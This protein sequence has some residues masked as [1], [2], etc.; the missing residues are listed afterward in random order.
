MVALAAMNAARNLP[1]LRM[2]GQRSW[3]IELER[4]TGNKYSPFAI[5]ASG[6]IC[7]REVRRTLLFRRKRGG[8]GHACEVH[9]RSEC[10]QGNIP[11]GAPSFRGYATFTP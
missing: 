1:F 5:R 2:L 6:S 3:N 8:S 11:P 10:R 7:W 4:L 9:Q